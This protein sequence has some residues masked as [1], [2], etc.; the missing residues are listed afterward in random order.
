MKSRRKITHY[1]E[2]DEA[3]DRFNRGLSHLLSV[4]KDELERREGAD[5]A[6]RGKIKRGPKAKPKPL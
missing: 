3:A 1:Y 4:S 5:R 2:G 6:R